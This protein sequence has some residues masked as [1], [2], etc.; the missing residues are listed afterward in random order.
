MPTSSE[1][2]PE[3]AALTYLAS[4]Y[5]FPPAS[6]RSRF[7]ALPRSGKPFCVAAA[8]LRAEQAAHGADA[9]RH[10]RRRHRG[11]RRRHDHQGSRS[12]SRANILF[13]GLD[14]L[15]HFQA[16][17]DHH[18]ARR[19]HQIQQAQR[20]HAR[21]CGGDRAA[22]HVPAG[23]SASRP[24][25]SRPAKHG[26]QKVRRRCRSAAIDPITMFDIDGVSIDAGRIWTESEGASGREIC[27]VGSDMVTNLFRYDSADRPSARTS[28]SAAIVTSI[29]G[30]LAAAGINLRL[31]ARQRASTFRT[32]LIK[33]VWRIYGAATRRVAGRVYPNADR[34]A[35]RSRRR[36]GA[37][38]H[39]QP[40]R[41]DF[42]EM[43]TTASRWKRRTCF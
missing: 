22:V 14:R 7:S 16:S 5:L 8:S 12:D 30:V 33:K 27:V 43:K 2:S 10:H 37:H 11:H 4:D 20:R 23:A 35:T 18:F 17:A 9:D 41:Q 21:R 15:H 39:A 32:R 29:I 3:R 40:A 38:D 13:A 42:R 34:R 36:S 1:P 25:R 26:D 28:G 24:M 6:A 31:L 19:V